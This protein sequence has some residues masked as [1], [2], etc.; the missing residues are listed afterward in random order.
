ML[1]RNRNGF[2]ADDA[3][4][5]VALLV[6]AEPCKPLGKSC[7]CCFLAGRMMMELE[8]SCDTTCASASLTDA[9]DWD[10]DGVDTSLPN[11]SLTPLDM[12]DKDDDDVLVLAALSWKK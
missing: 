7:C 2:E 6:E 4:V 5:S 12:E 9:A 11:M 8:A 10:A 3:D 1:G